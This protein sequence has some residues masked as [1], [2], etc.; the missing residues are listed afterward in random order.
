MVVYPL[1]K[2]DDHASQGVVVNST[3]FLIFFDSHFD[4]WVRQKRVLW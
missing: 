4:E 3:G 2:W 1:G